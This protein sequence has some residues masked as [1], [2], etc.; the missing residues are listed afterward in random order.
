MVALLC[1]GV[2]MMLDSFNPPGGMDTF[3]HQAQLALEPSAD[4][5]R[6]L[7][8][9][10]QGSGSIMV[11]EATDDELL[12]YSIMEFL[13]PENLSRSQ[14]IQHIR[15]LDQKQWARQVLGKGEA[16]QRDWSWAARSDV[17]EAVF[18]D[19]S[20]D[21]LYWLILKGSD[22]WGKK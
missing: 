6:V 17:I 20:E 9:L 16:S 8:G 14:A 3:W 7:L 12:D 1:W 11:Q 5:P 21:D 18:E 4:E 13:A 10:G 22:H 15:H 2:A 19:I